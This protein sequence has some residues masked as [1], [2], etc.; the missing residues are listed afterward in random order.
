MYGISD[1]LEASMIRTMQICNDYA[2]PIHFYYTGFIEVKGNS[3]RFYRIETLDYH[4]DFITNFA[5]MVTVDVYMD[6]KDYYQYV[7]PNMNDLY[8]VIQKKQMPENSNVP[9][10]GG[11]RSS[12]RYKALLLNPPEPGLTRETAANKIV[13]P[14]LSLTRVTFQFI[15]EC[16]YQL[17]YAKV[18]CL[19]QQTR[20]MQALLMFYQ[21]RGEEVN[22]SYTNWVE[23]DSDVPRDIIIPQGTYLKD[24]AL[25][26]QKNYGIYNHG[27]GTY[28]FDD[29][30][31]YAWFVYPIYNTKRYDKEQFR[32]SI[33]VI[34]P[35]YD[36]SEMPRTYETDNGLLMIYTASETEAD[37]SHLNRQL[38]EGTGFQVL[39][40][41]NSHQAGRTPAGINKWQLNGEDSLS[42]VTVIDRKDKMA[43]S[44]LV[45]ADTENMAELISSFS[46]NQGTYVTVTWRHAHPHLIWPCMP[47]KITYM[48]GEIKEVTGVVHEYHATL[49]PSQ[50][51]NIEQPFIC[52]LT[53]KIFVTGL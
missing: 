41:Q 42:T 25:Y 3:Y 8:G 30:D 13:D 10:I 15:D 46:G 37:K 1:G 32:L 29:E 22:I 20:P 17:Q 19:L 43:N 39:N 36:K 27:I 50:N 21:A 23:P 4:R 48:Q 33:T 6:T 14:A 51:S 28:V 52:T 49:V 34:N 5:D 53:M 31:D 47:C 2:K 16:A 26:L 18:A 9:L 38:D 12:K 11:E 44:K 40:V 7:V 45:M 35:K 24:L